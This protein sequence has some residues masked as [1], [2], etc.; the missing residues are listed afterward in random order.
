MDEYPANQIV[1][2]MDPQAQE[3]L[4]E[5]LISDRIVGIFLQENTGIVVEYETESQACMAALEFKEYLRNEK[6]TNPK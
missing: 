3:S 6:E 4:H 5:E 2:S 1:I